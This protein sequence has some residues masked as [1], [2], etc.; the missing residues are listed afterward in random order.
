MAETSHVYGE[1]LTKAKCRLLYLEKTTADSQK[2]RKKR[3][4]TKQH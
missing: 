3:A 4:N 1:F 2:E